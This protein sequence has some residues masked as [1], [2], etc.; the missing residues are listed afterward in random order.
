M[1]HVVEIQAPAKLMSVPCAHIQS[2]SYP[3]HVELILLSV[4]QVDFGFLAISALVHFADKFKPF[5][6]DLGLTDCT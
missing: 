5:A 3:G 1:L 4:T 6:G 2:R